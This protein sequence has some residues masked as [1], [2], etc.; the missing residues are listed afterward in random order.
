MEQ[1]ICFK[2]QYMYTVESLTWSNSLIY[3]T[4]PHNRINK[5]EQISHENHNRLI[6]WHENMHEAY[7]WPYNWQR[8]KENSKLDSSVD[9]KC[10]HLSLYSKSVNRG[11][12]NA[13]NIYIVIDA[14]RT[15]EHFNMKFTPKFCDR[16]HLI[17]ELV[18]FG[19]M[20]CLNSFYYLQLW[21]KF[22]IGLSYN[23]MDH[24]VWKKIH[25]FS[26]A[27]PHG[28]GSHLSVVIVVGV[29]IG[30]VNFKEGKGQSLKCFSNFFVAWS[31]F[32]MIL[33]AYHKKDWVESL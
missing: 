22:T 10:I 1:H 24:I 28:S 9:C 19:T 5:T 33:I 31:F 8:Y 11:Q 21:P 32:V 14:S 29:V 23:Y 12:R 7:R 3:C 15:P 16:K 6:H 26:S 25:I 13:L 17:T 2:L 20:F 27:V 4:I 30:A 18:S